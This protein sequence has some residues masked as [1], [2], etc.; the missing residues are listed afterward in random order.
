MFKLFSGI[1]WQEFGLQ[2]TSQRGRLVN[3]DEIYFTYF[4]EFYPKELSI[5]LDMKVM[6]W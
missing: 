4:K 5:C 6:S 3:E 1:F 2:R